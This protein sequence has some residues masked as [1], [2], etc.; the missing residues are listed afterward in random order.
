M[1]LLRNVLHPAERKS[2]DIWALLDQAAV[3]KAGVTVTEESALRMAAVW[4]CIRVISEDV[5]SLPL[6]VYERLDRGKRRAPEHPLYSLLHTAP[7]EE[8]TALQFRETL[9]AH[10][11][12]WGNAYAYIVRDERGVVRELWPLFPHNTR[13]RRNARTRALEYETRVPNEEH[14]RILNP[15]DVLHI[16]GLAYDGTSGYSPIK[17]HAQAIGVGL[18]AEEFSARFFGQGLN[19][20][21]FFEH[22]GSLSDTAYQRLKTEVAEKYAG[23]GRS[24]LT[25]ILEE[26][27]KFNRQ[28]IPPD[29]AQMIESRKMQVTEIARIFRVQPHKIGDLERATFSNV[30]NLA[31]DHVVSTLRPWLVRWEQ[32]ILCKLLSPDGPFFAEHAVEGLLRGDIQ[33]RYQSYATG[34]QWGWLSVNDIRELENLNPID[35]GDEYLQPLNM[36]T[37]RAGAG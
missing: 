16:A 7:N 27:M 28:A 26:N 31:I 30:E 18:A 32:A 1:G 6:H 21:G 29:D 10:V 35:G 14:P 4:A 8:M 2:T 34:R 24:H 11:L 19:L 23:L 3:T 37:A 15:A 5:S 12:G 36:S 22:P 33:A 17:L 13:A 9:T 20:G 25:M